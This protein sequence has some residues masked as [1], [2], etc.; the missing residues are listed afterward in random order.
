MSKKGINKAFIGFFKTAPG[1]GLKF[2]TTNGRLPVFTNWGDG[3][4]SN[5]NGNEDCGEIIAYHYDF[6]TGG[7]HNDLPCS[8]KRHF[9]CQIMSSKK[10]GN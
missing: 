2:Y 10:A 3:Q 4:P 1:L 7:I 8:Y 6:H 5:N 9:I